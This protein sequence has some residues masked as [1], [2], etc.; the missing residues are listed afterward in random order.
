M[1]IIFEER[2]DRDFPELPV[3]TL[4]A[5]YVKDLAGSKDNAKVTPDKA[6]AYACVCV[7]LHRQSHTGCTQAQNNRKNKE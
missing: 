2:I 7:C 1:S 6:N 3:M 5:K 4:S